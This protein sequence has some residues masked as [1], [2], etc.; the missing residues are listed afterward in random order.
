M[1]LKV[2]E[3]ILGFSSPSTRNTFKVLSALPAIKMPPALWKD[4][5]VIAFCCG[6]WFG[7]ESKGRQDY[8]KPSLR[9]VSCERL[10]R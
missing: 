6:G 5:A 1:S 3:W 7:H 9:E 2:T 8:T 10:F 4:S